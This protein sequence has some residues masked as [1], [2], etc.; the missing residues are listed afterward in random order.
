[1]NIKAQIARLKAKA[2]ESLYQQQYNLYKKS[3][4]LYLASEELVYDGLLNKK[5]H[6]MISIKKA[7]IKKKVK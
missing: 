2:K 7:P 5:F 3:Y 4:G 6:C 1:M